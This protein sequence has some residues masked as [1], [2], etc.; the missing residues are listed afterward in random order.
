MSFKKSSLTLKWTLLAW[1]EL[2]VR[3]VCKIFSRLFCQNNPTKIDEEAHEE[4]IEITK[5]QKK[6]QTLEN[7][8]VLCPS[9]FIERKKWLTKD[10]TIQCSCKNIHV[11]YWIWFLHVYRIH[12]KKF[13]VWV[14]SVKPSSYVHLMKSRT[15]VKTSSWLNNYGI[16][17]QVTTVGSK[18]CQLK[19]QSYPYCC[20]VLA[21]IDSDTV[22]NTWI[23]QLFYKHK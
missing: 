18:C 8:K 20:K 1:R 10:N 3:R 4:S 7:K 16:S 22:L 19:S 23:P 2:P 6:K 5:V 14:V 21:I 12:I 11:T 13:K 9:V 15:R 17:N